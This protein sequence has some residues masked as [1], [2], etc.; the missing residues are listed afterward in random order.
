LGSIEIEIGSARV[1]I[2]GAVDPGVL[3]QVLSLIG[4]AR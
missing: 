2:E 1:R 4:P 3:R